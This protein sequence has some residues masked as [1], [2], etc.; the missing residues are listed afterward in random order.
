MIGGTDLYQK[1]GV[2]RSW[3]F[4][5]LKGKV[6]LFNLL[7]DQMSYLSHGCLQHLNQT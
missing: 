7:T 5:V 1:G 2:D 6:Y 3:S 4:L